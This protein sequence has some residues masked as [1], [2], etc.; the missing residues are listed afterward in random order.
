LSYTREAE[1]LCPDR[2]GVQSAPVVTGA[3][4]SVADI[5]ARFRSRR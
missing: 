4:C 2:I 5:S 1:S 3:D